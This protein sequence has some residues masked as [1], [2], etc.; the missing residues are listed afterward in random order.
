MVAHSESVNSPKTQESVIKNEIPYSD[1]DIV[2]TGISDMVTDN[3]RRWTRGLYG[4]PARSGKIKDLSH[5]DAT[6]FKIHF[7]QA[8]AMDPQFRLMLEA[9]YEAIIDA[10]I[11]P[12]TAR[13]SRTGVFVGT[14]I[15]ES[16]EFWL[17]DPENING[18]NLLGSS[19][20]MFANRISY[21]FDF[22][23]PSHELDTACSSSLYATHQAVTTI[24]A[25]ECDAAIVG[26]LNL[27]L[28]PNV[29]LQCLKLNMLSQ[30]GKCKTFD[31]SA[32]GI[33]RAEAAVAIYLQ[34][35]KDARRVYATVVRTKTNTDGYKSE[36][37]TYPNGEKQYELIRDI[38]TEA[39]I[40]PADVSYVE[41]H[42]TGTKVGDRLEITSIDKLFC[43][44]RKTPLLIGSVKSNMG[45]LEPASVL[46]SIAKVLITMETG[47][48]PAN[49]HFNT[50]NPN[51]PALKE[52]RVRVV[53]KATPWNGGFMSINSFG[54]GS[55]NAHIILMSSPKSKPKLTWALNIIKLLP[56][57]IA[58]S[59]RTKEA[60][61][62]LLDKAKEYRN[63]D[64][65]HYDALF[66]YPVRCAPLPLFDPIQQSIWATI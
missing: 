1:S 9:I 45:H 61:H 58:V 2:I 38:Y 5:F 36:G 56:K 57:L 35:A 28:R 18:Y 26:G 51:I 14:F 19:R 20:S 42:G 46:C 29:S 60:V 7:K 44:D 23:G 4:L 6:F 37:I 30:D 54:F 62:T 8:H 12:T 11:N 64:G 53:D 24:R 48:I 49:L 33:V 15:S 55:T 16:E 32:D 27:V 39:G 21:A 40:K 52:G 3:E 10:G 31:I 22:T 41:A 66:L 13:G 59:D 17:R 65:R 25:G 47:V 34:K 63:D 43:K 50:R